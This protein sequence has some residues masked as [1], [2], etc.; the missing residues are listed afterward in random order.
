MAALTTK[1]QTRETR[2]KHIPLPLAAGQTVYQGGI[3]C[4]DTSTGTVKKGA[5]GSTTLL[6]IGEFD[7][8]LDNSVPTTTTNVLVNLDHEIVIRWYDNAT[9]ANAVAASTL[10]NDV[11]ILD[12]H[13]VT[14]ASSGNS[15]AGRV[16][17][18]DSTNGVGVEMYTL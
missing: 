17:M 9:G 12:D 14:T 18:V 4:G 15:K 7:E 3:A 8:N 10:F 16:W 11:Y 2:A 5:S 6:R 13:T 1:R